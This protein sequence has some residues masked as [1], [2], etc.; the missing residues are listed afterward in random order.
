MNKPVRIAIQDLQ[1]RLQGPNAP[2]VLDVLPAGQHEAYRVPA[3]KNACVYEMS[4]LKTVRK[5]APDQSAALVVVGAG[6]N[7]HDASMAADKLQRAGYVNV[8]VLDGGRAGWHAAGLPAEGSAETPAPSPGPTA[9]GLGTWQ[10][11]T[12]ESWLR[13][14]GRNAN[15]FHDGAMNLKRGSV[16]VTGDETTGDVAVDLTTL[17]NFDLEGDSSQPYFITHLL[18][19]DFLFAERHPEVA[20]AITGVSELSEAAATTATHRIDGQLTMRGIKAP[21]SLDTNVSAIKNGRLAAEAH[22]DLDRTRWGMVY[23]SARFF[24][25]LGMHTVFDQVSVTLRLVLSRA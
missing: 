13:F 22:F 24:A 10:V 2:L 19:D 25:H 12:E 17:R 18:S 8:N 9:I 16:R 14:V 6:G 3:S 11:D 7:S 5:L 21:L 4:F 20:Y 23:G 1:S 15:G